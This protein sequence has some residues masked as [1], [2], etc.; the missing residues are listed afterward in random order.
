M[1]TKKEITKPISNEKSELPSKKEK[2]K[3]SAKPS[4]KKC[5]KKKIILI[6]F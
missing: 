4:R 2:R 6:L 5:M 1:S 3:A